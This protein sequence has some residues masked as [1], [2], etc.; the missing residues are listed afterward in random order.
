MA[1]K[2]SVAG[3]AKARGYW[4]WWKQVHD[5]DVTFSLENVETGE[6]IGAITQ[7]KLSELNAATVKN[8]LLP[9]TSTAT[10]SE[11]AIGLLHKEI[12]KWFDENE[13]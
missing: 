4:F 7:W 10:V 11:E 1:T 13:T 6:H 3:E 2:V 8:A 5:H 9:C 12:D